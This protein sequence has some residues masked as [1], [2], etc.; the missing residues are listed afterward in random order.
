MGSSTPTNGEYYVPAEVKTA[1][2]SM[3]TWTNNDNVPHTVTSGKVIDNTPTPDKVFDSGIMNAGASY[4][5]VFEK[6]GAYDYYCMLHP[7]MVGKVTVS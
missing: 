7:Y 1:V 4:P 2:G 5:Y 6:A 3:V